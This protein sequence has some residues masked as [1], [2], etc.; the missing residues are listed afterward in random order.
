MWRFISF[1]ASAVKDVVREN[2]AGF[3][4]LD[5]FDSCSFFGFGLGR[6]DEGIMEGVLRYDF[7]LFVEEFV[8]LL[9]EE[10]FL[11]HMINL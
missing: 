10:E 9:F 6:V 3:A 4:F 1:G 7:S 5:C 11:V 8:V 2:I